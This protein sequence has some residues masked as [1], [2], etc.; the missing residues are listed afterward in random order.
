MKAARF[1]YVR[2]RDIGGGARGSAQARGSAKLIAGGQSLGP[3]LNLR[4]ARPKL[5]VDVSRSTSCETIEDEGDSWRIG[6]ASRMPR[7]RTAAARRL[8]E[9]LLRGRRAASPTA[10]CAIAARRRQP[11]ACR[12]GGRLAAGARGARRDV[13]SSARRAGKRSVP[14]DRFMTRRLHH[15]S[16]RTTRS[17]RRST[18]RSSRARR[19]LGLLQVLPQDRRIRRGQPRR[20][21]FDPA[22]RTRARVHRR[23]RRRAAA[24]RRAAA[25]AAAERAAPSAETIAAALGRACPRWMRSIRQARQLRVARAVQRAIAQS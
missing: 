25:Q 18:F 1:D 22:A 4:L 21:V 19:A 11:R 3:M 10:P 13:E 2:P 24:A 15:A 14:I 6:A 20:R 9:L 7:S 5:L 8:R 16:W 12:P 17:S 23:A